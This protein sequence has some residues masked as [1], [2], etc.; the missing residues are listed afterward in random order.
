[1]SK[2][3]S[4]MSIKN[5]IHWL[6]TD[7]S[8]FAKK[9][10]SYIKSVFNLQIPVIPIL[11]ISLYR[12]HLLVLNFWQSL[13][14]IF[15]FTPIFKA[16]VNQAAPNL[17]LYSGM[18]QVLGNLDIKIGSHV[19]MSGISTFCGRSAA[20]AQPKLII[21][22]NVD[23]GWQNAISVGTKVEI[24]DNVRLAG[25]VFL[26]GFP[27]HP[28]NAKAR[29][30]GLPEL[31]F[32]AKDIVLEQDVWVGTG[33]TILA[34]VTVGKGAIVAAASVVTKNVEAGTIV[35]GNPA[36]PVKKLDEVDYV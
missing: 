3:T 15:Y 27:G 19:R 34:G 26:A 4:S 32:Q 2:F 7:D 16:K 17:Y 35:A 13:I 11:H 20:K 23:I 33:A 29:A 8:Q 9:A 12:I 6:K 18:P 31:D 10:R 5:S 14:R 24:K 30:S 36:K 1:M 22:N 21:G 28:F 25:R